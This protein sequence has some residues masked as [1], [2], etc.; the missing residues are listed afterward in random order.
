MSSRMEHANLSPLRAKVP[1]RAQ[2]RPDPARRP[3]SARV[4]AVDPKH[5]GLARSTMTVRSMQ[6]YGMNPCKIIARAPGRAE[7]PRTCSRRRF[8]RVS[9]AKG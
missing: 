4:V 8:H 3:S 7:A 6:R 2:S 9:A 5:G 1:R